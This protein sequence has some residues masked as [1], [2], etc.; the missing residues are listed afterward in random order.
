M[1]HLFFT[2]LLSIFMSGLAAQDFTLNPDEEHFFLLLPSPITDMSELGAAIAK[3]NHQYYPKRK[4]KTS[5]VAINLEEKTI[6]YYVPNFKNKADAL[7]YYNSMSRH[8]SDI[9]DQDNAAYYFIISKK[10]LNQVLR[11]K[12]LKT[13]KDFF[14]QHYL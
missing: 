2:F 9:I 13:Y 12:S 8:K 1:K 7:H 10:N 5:T 6:F 11:T 14:K 3:H 4:L